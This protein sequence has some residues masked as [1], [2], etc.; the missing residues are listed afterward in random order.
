MA[1]TQQHQAEK[2]SEPIVVSDANFSET[3]KKHSLVFVD[4]W[5]A[6]CGPCR[7]MIPMI[8]ELAREY[9]GKVVFVKLNVDENQETA[10]NF[11]IMSIP[12]FVIMKDGS[13]AARLVGA[14]P[15]E[16]LKEELK[17]YL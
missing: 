14:M 9:A 5:A 8:D 1:K 15:K 2:I 12:T 13:E 7:M 6:W 16:K 4:F 3:T 11:G 17:K 10:S